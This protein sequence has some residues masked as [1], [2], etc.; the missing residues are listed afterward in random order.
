MHDVAREFRAQLGC[1]ETVRAN[2]LK[3]QHHSRVT[4]VLVYTNSESRLKKY[5]CRT[6]ST[7][8]QMRVSQH[9]FR[10]LAQQIQKLYKPRFRL[11]G[12]QEKKKTLQTYWNYLAWFNLLLGLRIT[13]VFFVLGNIHFGKKIK[14]TWV[15]DL[16]SGTDFR[17]ILNAK[18]V[19]SWKFKRKKIEKKFTLPSWIAAIA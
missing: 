16:K 14:A 11:L 13:I 5:S 4:W 10:P 18:S 15:E 1:A 6:T 3:P 9:W 8:Q 12:K 19:Q 17:W 7:F 2:V